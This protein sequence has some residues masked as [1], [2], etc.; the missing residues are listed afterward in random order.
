MIN[1]KEKLIN[2]EEIENKNI[3]INDIIIIVSKENEKNYNKGYVIFIDIEYN[4]V[5][6]SNLEN[7]DYNDYKIDEYIV[8][9]KMWDKNRKIKLIK[10]FQ[11]CLESNNYK[12]IK[13]SVT[14][15]ILIPIKSSKKKIIVDLPLIEKLGF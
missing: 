11:E 4:I 8:Y 5:T 1:I 3:E 7:S 6:L 15:N 2:Y 14:E 9:K 10:D 13:R 12:F